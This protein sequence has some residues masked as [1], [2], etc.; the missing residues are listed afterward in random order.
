MPRAVRWITTHINALHH[1][2]PFLHLPQILD[3]AK[4]MFGW[5][6]AHVG[7]VDPAERALA[8]AVLALGNLREQTF[9]A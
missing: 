2:T 1:N 5:D 6:T 4:R 7:R 9:D 8:Y 3:A